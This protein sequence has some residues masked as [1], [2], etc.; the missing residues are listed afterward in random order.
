MII[1]LFKQITKIPRCSGTHEPFIN[2]IKNYALKYDYICQIDSANN[3]LCYKQNQSPNI[4]L[5]SHYDIVCLEDGKIPQILQDGD[6]L[7]A[8][9]STL[10]ADNGIGCAYMLALMS[11]NKNCEFL[12]TCDE[13]IG[14][15]GANNIQLEIKSPNMLNLDSEAMGE[16]CI[17]CAGGLDIF[18]S[19]TKSII[20]ENKKDKE[21]YEIIVSGFDGGHSGVDI[22]K[23]IPN[24]IK[25]LCEFLILCDDVEI[26]DINGG[27]RINS[28]PK[29]AKAII[30]CSKKP[31]NISPN[32]TINPVDDKS[33]HFRVLDKNIL[34]FIIN[35]K[36][37]V[38]KYDKELD[39][40]IDSINLALIKTTMDDVTISLSARS[41]ENKNLNEIAITNINNLRDKG[42]EVTVEG[43]YPAWSPDTNEFTNSVL[44]IYKKYFKD[45]KLYAIHAGLECAIFKEKY[46]HLN[47]ASIGPDIH[48]PHSNKEYCSIS[49]VNKVYDIL[50]DIIK[51]KGN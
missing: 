25:V 7:Y 26:L 5:Q 36:N 4:C 48:F 49:S 43:K 9:D 35:M 19:T 27:E 17:G 50:K 14:L 45:A 10:G 15:I 46:P 47:I 40:V 3:I 32:I 41:M 24:A 18:A 38:L 20:K 13:E 39:V 22:N 28:I 31:I 23:D 33:E 6:K 21:L 51:E 44:E 1:E 12:F 11:E 8:K 29:Y 16:I 30:A 2:Y 34:S 42:F 37:G